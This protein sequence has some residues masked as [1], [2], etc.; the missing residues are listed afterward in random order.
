QVRGLL[1]EFAGAGLSGKQISAIVIPERIVVRRG[2]GTK[3]CE[4]IAKFVVDAAPSQNAGA[5]AW[6]QQDLDCAAARAIP[7]AVPLELTQT[8]WNATLQRWEFSLRCARAGDCVPFLVWSGEL[9][10]VDGISR[11]RA[12]RHFTLSTDSS[13]A[14]SSAGA[15]S[16]STIR[17]GQTATLVW[18]QAGIRV[19]LP[20]TCLDAGG[21]GQVVRVQLKNGPR[22]LR[23]EVVG[24]GMLRAAL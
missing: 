9:A 22:I 5:P 10:A 8:V 14:H 21:V 20:V 24:E 23:A 18:D 16:E 12:R 11:S 2:G 7:A 17:R 19:V 6:R 13:G 1:E 15:G 4:E 3:S